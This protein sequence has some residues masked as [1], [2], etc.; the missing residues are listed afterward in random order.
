VAIA[1]V[2]IAMEATCSPASPS[3][4]TLPRRN[5]A[6]ARL[7]HTLL[8]PAPAVSHRGGP[9]AVGACPPRAR[10][11]ADL[12]S[13]PDI[14][15]AIPGDM[16]GQSQAPGRRP[17]SQG[18]EPSE[19]RQSGPT[20]TSTNPFIYVQQFGRSAA[21]RAARRADPDGRQLRTTIGSAESIDL[22]LH[23]TAREVIERSGRPPSRS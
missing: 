14:A 19:R 7:R 5:L 6:G 13:S 3:Y 2:T 8:A 1:T 22:D 20:R 4:L 9:D 12:T 21:S 15:P 10:A 17:S 11:R 23:E 18:T 16:D